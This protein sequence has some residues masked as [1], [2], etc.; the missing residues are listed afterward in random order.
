M[1]GVLVVLAV[2]VWWKGGWQE[3]AAEKGVW[4]ELDETDEMELCV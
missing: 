4:R 2:L 1:V 3:L